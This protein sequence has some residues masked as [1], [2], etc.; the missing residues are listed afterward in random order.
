M[1]LAYVLAGAFL[2]RLRGGISWAMLPGTQLARACFAGSAGVLVWQLGVAWWV[3]L[4]VAVLT[5]G[6]LTYGWGRWFDIGHN[7]DPAWRDALYMSLRGL[8]LT[9]PAS[10]ALRWSVGAWPM[11][12]PDW[13]LARCRRRSGQSLV[14]SRIYRAGHLWPRYSRAPGCGVFWC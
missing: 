12:S 13:R 14:R 9:V 1:I 10:A 4:A 6:G 3:A 8:L 11:R 5:F 2:Y 7:H